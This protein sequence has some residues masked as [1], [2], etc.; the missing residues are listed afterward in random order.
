VRAWA[1]DELAAGR[2]TVGDFKN[3]LHAT[4][5]LVP[6]AFSVSPVLEAPRQLSVLEAPP[7]EAAPLS[8]ELDA[9]LGDILDRLSPEELGRLPEPVW[10]LLDFIAGPDATEA[11]L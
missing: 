7:D 6:A 4:R 1:L 2:V 11:A 9:L 3:G 10:A 5:A 8:D